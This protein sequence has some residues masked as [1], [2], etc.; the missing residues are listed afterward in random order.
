[1]RNRLKCEAGE[2]KRVAVRKEKVVR[3]RERQ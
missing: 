1:M 2:G 3:R